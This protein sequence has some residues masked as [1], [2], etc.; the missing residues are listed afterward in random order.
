MAMIKCP[1]CGNQISSR[2]TACIKCGL[3]MSKIFIC[4]ECSNVM[5]KDNLTVCSK[6]GCPIDKAVYNDANTNYIEEVHTFSEE[7]IIISIFNKVISQMSTADN[8]EHYFI[9][10]GGKPLASSVAEQNART[11]FNIPNNVR[12]Y[13]VTSANAFGGIKVGGKGFAITPKGIY[14]TDNRKV[15]GVISIDEFMESEIY[16]APYTTIGTHSFNATN[17]EKLIIML[18]DLQKELINALK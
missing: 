11:V 8:F 2:A 1:E 5:S 12:V 4:P 15:R 6:C 17:K 16:S 18:K 14:Y 3:P 7:D 10:G 13:F 9:S